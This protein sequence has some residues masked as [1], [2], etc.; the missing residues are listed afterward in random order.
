MEATKG[1]AVTCPDAPDMCHGDSKTETIPK[2]C[3]SWLI[4]RIIELD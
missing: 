2:D 1:G 3:R 4:L